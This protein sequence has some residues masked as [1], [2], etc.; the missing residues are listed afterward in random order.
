M[1][2]HAQSIDRVATI[3]R[4]ALRPVV[5]PPLRRGSALHDQGVA[6]TLCAVAGFADAIGYLHLGVF[7]AN[8]TGNT[9]L[10]AIGLA[11][12]QWALSADR[13]LTLACFFGGAMFGR[14]LL[15]L[16]R[17]HPSLPLLGEAALLG[18]ALWID[19]RHAASI[20][21]MAAAMGTQAT[22]MTRFNGVAVSTVVVTSTMTRLA[23][24]VADLLVAPFGPRADAA[25]EPGGLLIGTW[26][27]YAMGAAAAALLL[28]LMAHPLAVACAALFALSAWLWLKGR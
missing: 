27:S 21:L 25:A 12:Q 15:T 6:A 17:Q 1:V 28:P 26:F 10:L 19:A 20:W 18:L 16:S 5:A 4:A 11:Q 14:A 9:V 13:L 2:R 3:Q 24:S 22:A 8:M 7:A 23:Q